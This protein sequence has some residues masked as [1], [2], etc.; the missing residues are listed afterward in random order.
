M[1]SIIGG[2]V[3][4]HKHDQNWK[5]PQWNRINNSRMDNGGKGPL[6]QSALLPGC[7]YELQ[8]SKKEVQEAGLSTCVEQEKFVILL[9]MSCPWALEIM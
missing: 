1:C 7:W 2:S 4:V 9:N 8:G 6:W 5:I 3:S